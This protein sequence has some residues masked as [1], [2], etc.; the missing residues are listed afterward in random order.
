MGWAGVQVLFL[1]K[2]IDMEFAKQLKY[3]N[4]LRWFAF[5]WYCYIADVTLR[6]QFVMVSEKESRSVVYGMNF[7]SIASSMCLLQTS[8]DYN[9]S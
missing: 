8:M 2:E 4:T 5:L 7:E 6:K 1:Q 9:N 3:F